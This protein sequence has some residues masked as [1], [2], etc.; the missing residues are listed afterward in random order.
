MKI[1]S[2]QTR[3]SERLCRSVFRE[4]MLPKQHKPFN[5]HH[6]RPN[7]NAPA[8]SVPSPY[9]VLFRCSAHGGNRALSPGWGHKDATRPAKR[10]HRATQPPTRRDSIA[11]LSHAVFRTAYSGRAHRSF[12]L[13]FGSSFTRQFVINVFTGGLRNVLFIEF[14]DGILQLC[15]QIRILFAHVKS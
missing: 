9:L 2:I 8:L 13:G 11:F 14:L 3:F 6:F 12:G 15:L 1:K 4:F 7:R 10:P 5:L